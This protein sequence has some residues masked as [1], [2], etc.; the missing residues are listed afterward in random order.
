VS[1]QGYFQ[2]CLSRKNFDK[3]EGDEI[4]VRIRLKA[5]SEIV[6]I[7]GIKKIIDQFCKASGTQSEDGGLAHHLRMGGQAL[8]LL[9]RTAAGHRSLHLTMER[10]GPAAAATL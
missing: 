2:F 10:P 3:S 1:L 5:D 8:D 6:C 9:T 7:I 4:W